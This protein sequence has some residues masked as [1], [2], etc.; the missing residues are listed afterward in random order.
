MITLDSLLD[1]AGQHAHTV[2]VKLR[3]D[4]LLPQWLIVGPDGVPEIYA[5]PW[6]NE[7]DKLAAEVLIRTKMRKQKTVMY[8]FV[9]EAWVS[10]QRPGWKPGDPISR[11]NRREMVNALACSSSEKKSRSW[12]ILRDSRGRVIGLQEELSGGLLVGGWVDSLLDPIEDP[13]S[14]S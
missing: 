9:G 2:L 11:T 1:L 3:M 5:T 14:L 8:S 12:A 10:E 7:A 13:N 4:K 6:N